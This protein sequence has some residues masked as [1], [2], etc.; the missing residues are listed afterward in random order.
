MKRI[1][2]IPLLIAALLIAVTTSFAD[3]YKL[4]DFTLSPA[5]SAEWQCMHESDVGWVAPF[6]PPNEFYSDCQNYVR[7]EFS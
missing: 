7:I 6:D 5:L 3:D 2:F 4:T 1:A